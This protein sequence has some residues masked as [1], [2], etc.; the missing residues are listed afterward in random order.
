MDLGLRL[1]PTQ[2]KKAKVATGRVGVKDWSYGL[3]P[4]RSDN[5]SPLQSSRI[6]SFRQKLFKNA[7]RANAAETGFTVSFSF[8]AR[9]TYK[10]KTRIILSHPK[11]SGQNIQITTARPAGLNHQSTTLTNAKIPWNRE[12]VVW[13]LP[14]AAAQAHQLG[15]F[16][17]DER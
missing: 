15:I 11:A 13:R 4:E 14:H 9:E 5:P 10:T 12:P 2:A 16:C 7:H 1:V 8:L 17:G 3:R 6:L